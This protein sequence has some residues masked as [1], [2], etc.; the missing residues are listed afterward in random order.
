[1]TP[2]KSQGFTL[3]ELVTSLALTA[4]VAT[5]ASYFIAVPV[6]SYTDLARRAAL[7]D[8]AETALRRAGR[9][10]RRA[11]PNSVRIRTNGS[12]V[13]IEMLDTLDGVRYRAGPPPSDPDKELDFSTADSAFNSIG[14][15]S[16]ISK[17]YSSTT[18]YLSVYNVGV[19]GAN[20]Y[21]LANVITPPGTRIDIVADSIANEDNVTLTPPFRFTYASPSQRLFLVAGPV[22]YL[23]DPVGGTLTRYV[24]YTIASDHTTR[25][26]NAE[27]LAAGATSSII[28][29]AVSGCDFNYSAGTAQRGGLVSAR[30]EVADS[31]E[32]VALLH[33]VHVM[34]VP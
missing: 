19:A 26:S 31:G 9:D 7:V 22:S 1:M 18:A 17:P 11:L 2:H 12:I 24:G 6:K 29:D 33:Q 21:E 16:G 25:D 20:A 32:R 23:C 5:F 10:L 3:I 8:R 27:L 28:S 14:P 4:I 30:L 15:F 13:A 34:N